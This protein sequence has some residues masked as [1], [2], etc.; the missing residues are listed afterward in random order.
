M[1]KINFTI[2]GEL[3]KETLLSNY[4]GEMAKLMEA[5]LNSI[6]KAQATEQINAAPYERSS[7]RIT[8]RNGYRERTLNTRIGSLTLGVPKLREGTFTTEIFESYQRSEQ[9]LILS[10]M[11]MVIQG[12]S[13]R[14]VTQITEQLCGTSFSK[15]TISNLCK[16]LDPIVDEFR[17]RPLNKEYPFVIVDA[18]YMKVRANKKVSPNALLIAIGI[19]DDGYREILGFT[20]ALSESEISWG[21]F[22]EYLKSRGLKGVDFVTSDDHLGLVKAINKCFPGS[23]WQRCQTHFSKNMLDKTPKQYKE[24]MKEKLNDMYNASNTKLAKQHRDELIERFEKI[25]PKAVNILDESFSDVIANLTLPQGYRRRLRT[26]NSIERLNEELRR[27]ERVIRI[28]PNEASLIRLMGAV[29]IEHHEKWES[30][31][32]YLDMENYYETKKLKISEIP[33]IV[34]EVTNAAME[35]GA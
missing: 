14:K 16:Q 17:N 7:Q 25:A 5:M 32:K 26:S 31:R 29:L 23:T 6:L 18:I 22:F 9:A 33:E 35:K 2:D 27:R 4:D 1:A 21:E 10:M 24:E 15:S 13:T 20:V 30:G 19:N 8:S 11:Q 12:V 34:S 3:L 28:F